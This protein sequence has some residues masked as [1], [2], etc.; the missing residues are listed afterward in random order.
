MKRPQYVAA[1]GIALALVLGLV[2]VAQ[3]AEPQH[4]SAATPLGAVVSDSKLADQRGGH[5]LQMS[6]ANLNAT[7]GNNKAINTVTGSNYV[8]DNAFSSA[9]GVSTVV[10]NSGNNVIIQNSTILNLKMQ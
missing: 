2:P 1:T 7:L 9:S 4:I 10:Q 6:I 8:T 3:A 5:E